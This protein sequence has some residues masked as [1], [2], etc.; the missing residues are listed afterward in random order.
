MFCCVEALVLGCYEF[1]GEE[2][3]AGTDFVWHTACSLGMLIRE[4]V[5]DISEEGSTSHTSLI[6]NVLLLRVTK[7]F[8]GGIAKT[9]KIRCQ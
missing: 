2:A 3:C 1:H 7:L 4:I 8:D 5:C 9:S 6:D